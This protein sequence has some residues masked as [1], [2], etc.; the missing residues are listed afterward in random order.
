MYS[1]VVYCGSQRENIAFKLID[2]VKT[3]HGRSF[4]NEEGIVHKGEVIL[5]DYKVDKNF[6]ITN[7]SLYYPLLFPYNDTLL[8]FNLPFCKL[9]HAPNFR[10]PALTL[11]TDDDDHSRS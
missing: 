3:S 8:R 6:H 9:E 1:S 2:V 4:L 5:I 10:F 11:G 7:Y